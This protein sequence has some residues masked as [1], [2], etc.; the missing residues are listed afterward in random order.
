VS[1]TFGPAMFCAEGEN[2][3][4]FNTRIEEAVVALGQEVSGNR[5]YN[6]TRPNRP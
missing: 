5:D 2:I 4:R 3:R 1:V 6:I